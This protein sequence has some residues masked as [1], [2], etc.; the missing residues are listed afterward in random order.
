MKEWMVKINLNLKITRDRKKSYA[1][2]GKIPRYFR[3]REHVY[4]KVRPK[5]SSLKLGSCP[6]LTPRYSAPF[7]ILTSTGL[8]AFELALAASIKSHNM[9]HVSLLK[10]YVPDPNH[11]ID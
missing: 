5:K 9:F 1:G 8:V 3:V 10:K 6:K 4:L 11:I 2:K 7:E